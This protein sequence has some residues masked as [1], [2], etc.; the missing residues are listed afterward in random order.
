MKPNASVS[1]MAWG[2][3]SRSNSAIAVR[4]PRVGSCPEPKPFEVVSTLHCLPV[5]LEPRV[6]DWG[7]RSNERRSTSPFSRVLRRYWNTK[8]RKKDVD[9][10][11]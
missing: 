3:I 11:A 4:N 10:T 6:D 8:C 5:E 7:R 1:P 2:R 9:E